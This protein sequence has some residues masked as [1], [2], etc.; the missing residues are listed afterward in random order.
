M[1]SAILPRCRRG[2]R[3]RSN[4]VR[5]VL[6]TIVT[7][8]L[9]AG[10]VGSARV[11]ASRPE[12]SLAWSACYA[13]FGPFECATIRVPLDYDRPNG[14]KISV[15]MVR[16]PAANPALRQGSIFLNPG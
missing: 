15:A 13:D 4:H 11:S 10:V 3:V 14:S 7:V 5:V 9:F 16:L 8:S 1:I 12:P 6:A 2:I